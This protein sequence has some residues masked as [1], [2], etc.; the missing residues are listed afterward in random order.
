[1]GSPRSR[2]HTLRTRTACPSGLPLALSRWL[3][4]QST[5]G[6]SI[7]LLIEP[8][9][10]EGILFLRL[11]SIAGP[12]AESSRLASDLIDWCHAIGER[13]ELPRGVV[14]TS[15]DD[16]FCM[17][18]PA[19]TDALDALG[20]D[21]PAATNAVALLV[22]PTLA[23]LSGDALGPAWELALACDLR[24]AAAEIHVGSPEIR[25]RRMPAAGGTQRLS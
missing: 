24:V 15:A 19:T 20:L 10:R 5:A 17:R 6:G 2:F 3:R 4:Y 11:P 8:D 16:A 18:S 23:V 1:L 21:W 14:L 22:P 12:G 25:L 7:Q 9:E 13:D